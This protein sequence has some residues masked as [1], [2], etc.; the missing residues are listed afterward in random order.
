ML[1][2]CLKGDDQ[3]YC[4][5][6]WTC[7]VQTTFFNNIFCKSLKRSRIHES[8]L[9]KFKRKKGEVLTWSN[10]KLVHCW[11]PMPV[12]IPAQ[13]ILIYRFDE[14]TVTSNRIFKLTPHIRDQSLFS[15]FYFSSK[16]EHQ[17]VIVSTTTSSSMSTNFKLRQTK[18]NKDILLDGRKVGPCRP[19]QGSVPVGVSSYKFSINL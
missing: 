7:L 16:N 12:I 9:I 2:F 10:S 19:C 4:K 13:G 14:T 5:C 15:L 3:P 6:Q 11:T 17:S 1:Y 18:F 8:N